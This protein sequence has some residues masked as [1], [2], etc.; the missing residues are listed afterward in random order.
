[1]E[2]S[3][4]DHVIFV[5]GASKSSGSCSPLSSAVQRACKKHERWSCKVSLLAPGGDTLVLAVRD[6]FFGLV[7]GITLVLDPGNDAE[8]PVLLSAGGVTLLHGKS[9]IWSTSV[10]FWKTSC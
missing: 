8:A 7:G 3:S 2:P 5:F 4:S 6:L 9:A 10:W 1:M